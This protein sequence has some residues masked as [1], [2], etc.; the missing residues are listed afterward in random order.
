MLEIQQAK[1]TFERL[2]MEGKR[3][4]AKEF[5]EQY[6]NKIAASSVSGAVQQQLGTLAAA[7]RQVISMPNMSQE[8]KDEL[9]K[10]I[11]DAQYK[12]SRR[13]LDVTGETTPPA[14][15]P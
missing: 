7:R 11:D 14:S 13:F 6:R 12:M 2:L 9:L 1:G 8:K 5:L 10:R 4:E 3:E 15:Q